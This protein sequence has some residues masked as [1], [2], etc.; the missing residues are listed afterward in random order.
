MA[1]VVN[2][3]HN[4]TPTFEY[5]S[6]LVTTGSQTYKCVWTLAPSTYPRPP[7]DKRTREDPQHNPY[8]VV[9]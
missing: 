3:V 4:P 6:N 5:Y 9:R 2:T 7:L 1:F 8:P